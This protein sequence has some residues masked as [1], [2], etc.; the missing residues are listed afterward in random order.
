MVIR[1]VL[2]DLDGTITDSGP[3]IMNGVRYALKKA[4]MREASEEELRSFIGPPLKEQFRDFCGITDEEAAEMVR[5][6][7]EYYTE[8]GIFENAVY[9]GVI[10][11]LSQLKAAGLQIL[12]A[13][14][15]P[16]KFAKIIAEHFDFA[17]YR[18]RAFLLRC[19]E[20]G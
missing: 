10:S 13:T 1:T 12:L 16:E 4:G 18:V 9:D 19:E 6:Y 8:K 5:L 14:S 7:R 20:P 11:M 2:F 3:G 17:R 15:K